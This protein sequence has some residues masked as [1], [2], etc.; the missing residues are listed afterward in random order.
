M[1]LELASFLGTSVGGKVFGMASDFLSEKR[2]QHREELEFE[3]K[4]DL[5]IAGHLKE[6][7]EAISKPQADGTYSPLSWAMCYVVILFTCTYCYATLTCFID[8]PTDI[9]YTKDPQ[10]AASTF[11]LLFGTISWDIAN[12]RVLAMSKAGVGFLM[13]YPIIFVLTMVVTGDKPKKR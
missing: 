12:N 10:E 1:I 3:H 13:C 6:H 4:K 7:Y 11:S 8:N 9:I 5:A 2:I